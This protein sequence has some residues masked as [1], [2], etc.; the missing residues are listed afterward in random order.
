MCFLILS[1]YCVTNFVPVFSFLPTDLHRKLLVV[2][3][4]FGKVFTQFVSPEVCQCHYYNSSND[5]D[6]VIM[7]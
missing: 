2:E 1:L 3:H 6:S 5:K 4:V 7:R